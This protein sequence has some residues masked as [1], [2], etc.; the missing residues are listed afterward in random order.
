MWRAV[1]DEGALLYP[2]FVET[3]IA[4]RPMYMV[5]IFAGTLYLTGFILMIWNL[6]MTVKGKD[7]VLASVRAPQLP[8]NSDA[9]LSAV[10]TSVPV[11]LATGSVVFGIV[12]FVADVTVAIASII[13]LAVITFFAVRT[14]GKSKVSG[15]GG[16]QGVHRALEGRPLAFTVL[17]LTAILIGGIAELVPTLFVDKAIP[18]KG[19]IQTP[20]TPARGARPR[21][22]RARGLLRL[23][24][25][26][27]AARSVSEKLRY[28][29]SV[30][31][32][33]SPTSMTTRIQWGSETHG[34]RPPPRSA[35]KL[36]EPLALPTHDRPALDV[37]GLDHARLR[38][39]PRRQARRR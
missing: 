4:I 8:K 10:L 39:A 38:L 28:G 23:P 26:N 36:S 2:S 13:V 15:T 32:G 31:G 3:L 9:P 14:F 18:E 24:Q 22:L 25:P 29:E 27:D 35:G 1:T 21:H 17:T 12:F 33:P 5:R 34:T 11:L 20:Y 37:P 16:E 6:I 19:T 30:D 7:P